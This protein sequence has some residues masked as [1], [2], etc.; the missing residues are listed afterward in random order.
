MV[1]HTAV[2]GLLVATWLCLFRLACSV[3]MYLAWR[4]FVYPAHVVLCQLMLLYC[5]KSVIRH[6]FPTTVKKSIH[7]LLLGLLDFVLFFRSFSCPKP[8]SGSSAGFCFSQAASLR[9]FFADQLSFAA[10]LPFVWGDSQLLLLTLAG[11]GLV[12]LVSF[13][14]FLKLFWVVYLPVWRVLLQAG[15]VWS[16][17]KL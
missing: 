4:T 17:R 15:M 13:R 12:N 6:N 11:R 2:C 7:M 3:L 10:Q 16:Q 9:G 8:V 14:D 1:S 5:P